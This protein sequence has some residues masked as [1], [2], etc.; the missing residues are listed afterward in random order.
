MSI[1]RRPWTNSKRSANNSTSRCS[2]KRGETDVLKI[3]REALDFARANNRNT[4]IFDTAGRLQIDE[5]LVQEL[6]RLRDLIKPQEILLVLDA[7]T[8]QEAVNVATHFDKALNITG[9]I[10]T[11]LDGDARG[12]AA[13]SMKAVTGKPI[14]FAGVG[15]KLEDFE[16]FHPER[17]AS[18][19]LG[20][21]DVVSLVE[22]AAEAVDLDEARR[23]EEKMR[24]GQFTLEDFL[25]Q[26]RQMKKLGSLESIVG[27]LPGGAEAMKGQDLCK[28]EKE[29]L[30]MEAMI[31]AM[32]LQE[33]RNPQILNAKRR[34]RIA[35]GS[36]VTVAEL[37]TMLN[38]FTQMQQM[39]KKMGKFQKMMT[40]MG[41]GAG[42]AALVAEL[43][44]HALCPVNS[45]MTAPYFVALLLVTAG[46]STSLH[47]SL[48]PSE[49]A[50]LAQTLANQKA[51][52][53]YQSAPFTD[54]A[55]AQMVDGKW[56]WHK[57]QSS[58]AK[59]FEA[60]VEIGNDGTKPK[61]E[62]NCVESA[63]TVG[64]AR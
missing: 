64:V 33:R 39:M 18:R 60:S 31:C 63:A 44:W 11:K 48:R 24:K 41:G 28:Q 32:T 49:A 38:K 25:D 15:E 21:G 47:V 7:A 54:D 10:L 37:N 6:V 4:L 46:C 13:L 3:A 35:K 27:M 40:R 26:L 62:V 43:A 23:M 59:T 16:P 42:D 52:A 22:K 12:G 57:L 34:Q 2:C 55:P 61:V 17:M 20:M 19:I 45:A 9:S 5:P 30:H 8:G 56:V 50:I 51:R 1:V 14:K 53:L 29:M 36:G 58:G